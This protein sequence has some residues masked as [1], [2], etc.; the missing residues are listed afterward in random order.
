MKGSSMYVTHTRADMGTRPREEATMNVRLSK[1]HTCGTDCAARNPTSEKPDNI[2]RKVFM[3]LFLRGFRGVQKYGMEFL[4][5]KPM[6][7]MRTCISPTKTPGSDLRE[8]RRV[9]AWSYPKGP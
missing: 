9:E 2:T 7:Q 6:V 1:Q 3:R 5:L 8:L 4:I